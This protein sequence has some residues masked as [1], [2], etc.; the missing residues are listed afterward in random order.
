MLYAKTI[1]VSSISSLDNLKIGQ[2]FQ[3]EQ[4]Q[5]GQ[6]L[7]KT[8][9][10]VSVVRWQNGKMQTRD[11]KANKPLRAFAKIYGSK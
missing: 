4:N 6:Y 9:A 5:R 3:N 1:F 7:G 11:V 10:G 8:N 2:W